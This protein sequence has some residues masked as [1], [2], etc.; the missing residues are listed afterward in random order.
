MNE[1]IIATCAIIS[2]IFIVINTVLN[3]I[4]MMGILDSCDKLDILRDIKIYIR[5]I[6]LDDNQKRSKI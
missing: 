2:T 4:K 6:D 1:T 3:F 5:K